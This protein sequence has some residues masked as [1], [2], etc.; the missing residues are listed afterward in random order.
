M[1]DYYKTLGVKETDNQ[2]SIKRA[3]RKAALKYHPDKNSSSGAAEMMKEINEAY[4]ILS[5]PV[6]R[7]QYDNSRRPFPVPQVRVVWVN[8]TWAS[9][10]STVHTSS[11]TYG[12]W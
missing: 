3:Y 5:D 6:K 12:G 10:N 8:Y 2:E 11:S 4:A 7:A 9:P 1:K